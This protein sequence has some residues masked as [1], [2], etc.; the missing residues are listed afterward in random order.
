[1]ASFKNICP[2]APAI[3]PSS[4]NPGVRRPPGR[5]FL[6]VELKNQILQ[7]MKYLSPQKFSWGDAPWQIIDLSIAGKVNI[8]VDNNTIITLGTRL[9]QQHNEFM[10]VAKW[11]EWAIQQDGL[12]ENLQKNLYEILE[13]NLPASRIENRAEALRRMKECLITRRSMLNLSN[14]GLTS[15][16]E[17]LPPH[18]IEFYCSKN[19]LTAL[20][21]VMP[22]WL[23]VLDC[24]DNVLILLPKVQPSKL[25]VLKCY[26]NCIIW[27]PELSTNLRVIN[28]S[29]NFLQ[30]LPPSM[31]QYLYK[32][33]CAGNNINSIPDEMLENLTRLKV[34]DCS[35]NDLISSP[36]L[37]PKLI[38]YYCG[39]NKFKTVQV[40]QPQSLKVFDCN[41]NPWDKDNLPTLLKA[42]E[43]LKKQQGLK[44][45]LDFLHKEGQVD[46]EGLEELEDLMDLEFLDDPELLERVK[47]QE[48]LELL[49]QQLGLL[50]LERQQDSQ[51]VNQQ[52]EHEPESASRVKR[53][54]SEVDSESTMKRKRFM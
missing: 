8:Q 5:L 32:L 30:F 23:L 15:L 22:K 42:V 34:F 25:M 47:V 50:S 20:P 18:L 51:P 11:C 19:V 52:S 7:N 33:S 38:I 27:L 45:L 29:E 4:V 31:P 3:P 39:E 41:G 54:L 53:D 10:M 26:E 40:P 49:D 9:N 17:N 35:S 13:E 21:K 16:P 48:D 37:P 1:M 28:C 36:R 14:L 43:G 6:S 12:Q 2:F 24:T 44:D 46:L